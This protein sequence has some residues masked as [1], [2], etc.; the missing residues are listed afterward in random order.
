MHVG[1]GAENK[2]SRVTAPR[3]IKFTRSVSVH[4]D[5]CYLRCAFLGKSQNHSVSKFEVRCR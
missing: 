5:G 2:A 1:I 3:L 4:D